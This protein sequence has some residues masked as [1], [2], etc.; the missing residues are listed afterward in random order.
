MIKIIFLKNN[1]L[2]EKYNNL[3]Y[4]IKIIKIENE[5][6]KEKKE[7]EEKELNN[8]KEITKKMLIKIYLKDIIIKK[9]K[10]EKY[11]YLNI[12]YKWHYISLLEKEKI[13]YQ[14]EKRN[15]SLKALFLE[16]EKSEKKIKKKIISIYL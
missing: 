1:S 14:E 5:S 9:A 6:L 3:D 8:N 15:K 13:L 16:K 4:N 10:L 12:L 11:Y 7:L 2:N